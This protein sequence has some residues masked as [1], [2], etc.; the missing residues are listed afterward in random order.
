MK[1]DDLVVKY[2]GEDWKSVGTPETW[3]GYGMACMLAFIDGNT[4]PQLN[5]MAEYLGVEVSDIQ[6]PFFNLLR[7]GAFYNEFGAKKDPALT[8]DM[9]RTDVLCAWG[10]VAGIASGLI[11]RNMNNSPLMN[12][13][14]SDARKS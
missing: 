7:S 12:N 11:W 14:T 5:A 1:Y 4:E 13:V 3:G 8:G 9:S 6:I 2:C 10:H